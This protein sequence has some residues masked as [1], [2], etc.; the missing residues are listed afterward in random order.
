MLWKI[1]LLIRKYIY[2]MFI[3]N[4]I[5]TY[6]YYRNSCT[7][8]TVKRHESVKLVELKKVFK[9]TKISKQERKLFN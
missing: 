3:I 8:I 9:L 7:I 1:C 2:C 4:Q 6:N 5:N